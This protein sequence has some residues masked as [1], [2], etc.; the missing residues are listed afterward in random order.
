M[1]VI[2]LHLHRYQLN[3]I[4]CQQNYVIIPKHSAVITINL[5]HQIYIPNNSSFIPWYLY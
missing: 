4:S 5:F 1:E 2:I 3:P